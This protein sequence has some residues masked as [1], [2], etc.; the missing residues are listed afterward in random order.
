M[1]FLSAGL[2][3]L[4]E[5]VIIRSLVAVV[6]TVASVMVITA[7][8]F[9]VYAVVVDDLGPVEAL[10]KG[11]GVA[12]NN[13]IKTL[14]LFLLLLVISL[15][16]S[17]LIGFL[18]GILTIPLGDLPSRIILA[19]VNAVV[20]SFIPVVMMISFMSFYMGLTAGAG[21][22]EPQVQ[23]AQPS[24]PAPSAPSLEEDAPAAEEEKEEEKGDSVE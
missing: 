1:A 13:F 7:L 21:A 24:Q 12:K 5:S 11:I 6:V 20:Q 15:I 4:G 19:L 2:L 9:P 3:L 22:A 17:L 8:I 18:A 23:T 14:L 16:I 10:K